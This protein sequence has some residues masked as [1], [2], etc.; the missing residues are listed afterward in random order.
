MYVYDT[1]V[2]YVMLIY[3]IPSIVCTRNLD[4]RV[5]GDEPRG[6]KFGI[7]GQMEMYELIAFFRIRI[8]FE[9]AV[10]TVYFS[11][12]ECSTVPL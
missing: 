1:Y 7:F 12:F 11:D 2:M 5:L 6:S 3:A 9:C 8:R 4:F 10:A